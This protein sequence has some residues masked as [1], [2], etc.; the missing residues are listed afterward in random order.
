[1]ET[2]LDPPLHIT[3]SMTAYLIAEML[4]QKRAVLYG[5]KVSLAASMD[6]HGTFHLH[7]HPPGMAHAGR[8][9]LHAHTD[10][11]SEL[12]CLRVG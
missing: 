2:P 10:N 9:G 12:E 4:T 8:P 6:Y 1:M 3:A 5:Q 7:N 11:F